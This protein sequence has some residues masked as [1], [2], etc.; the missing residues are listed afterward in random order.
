MEAGRIP[1]KDSKAFFKYPNP[2]PPAPFPAV[3][4]QCATS[5]IGR[6]FQPALRALGR[7]SCQELHVD[8]LR[9]QGDAKHRPRVP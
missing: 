9:S 2:T 3:T 4:N 5:R 8:L 6:R 7:F 1:S